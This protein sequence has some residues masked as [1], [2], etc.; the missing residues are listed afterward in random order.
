MISKETFIKTLEFIKK[1]SEQENDFQL[2]LEKLSDEEG[3]YAPSIYSEYSMMLVKV[4]GEALNDVDDDIGYFI[5]E[6][7]AFDYPNMKVPEEKCPMYND[8]VIYS[9]PETLYDY[10][11]TK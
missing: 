7:D 4:L 11:T 6:L 1:K 2:A 3:Y 5:W 9:S 10:L 8:K